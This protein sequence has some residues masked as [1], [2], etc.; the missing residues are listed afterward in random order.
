M[1][2]NNYKNSELYQFLIENLN[3]ENKV[4]NMVKSIVPY[5]INK[6][7]KNSLDM[8]SLIFIPPVELYKNTIYDYTSYYKDFVQAIAL[9]KLQTGIDSGFTIKRYENA[10]DTTIAQLKLIRQKQLIKE[11]HRIL[12]LKQKLEKKKRKMAVIKNEDFNKDLIITEEN[13]KKYITKRYKDSIKFLD[14]KDLS[15]NAKNLF[16]VKCGKL[17]YNNPFINKDIKDASVYWIGMCDCGNFR[18][19]QSGRIH[20]YESCGKCDENTEN[21]VGKRNGHLECIDQRYLLNGKHTMRLYIKCKCDCGSIIV[22]PPNDFANGRKQNCGKTCKFSIQHRADIGNANSGNFK[23]LFY[24]K[25]NVGKIGRKDSNSNSS[26][27]YLGVTLNKQTNKYMS[28]ITFQGKKEV[29]GY[30]DKPEMAYKVR[31]TAQNMLHTKLLAELENDEFIQN[32]KYLKKFYTK[33]CMQVQDNIE[34]IENIE[35]IKES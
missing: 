25:T 16:N 35:N 4:N 22:I 6:S 28:Y 26:T 15:K 34:I 8:N 19:S 31:M 2:D 18:V 13:I 24:K 12:A 29:L 11:Q 7:T 14:K 20:E 3:D 30:Y 27:G 32:N 17:T 5:L 33:I 9:Y 1:E 23:T 10:Y 21:Y